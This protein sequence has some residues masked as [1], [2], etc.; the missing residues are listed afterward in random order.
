MK[1][2]RLQKREMK[3]AL[4]YIIPSFVGFSFITLI[5]LIVSFLLVFTNW[6]GS[7]LDQIKITGFKNASYILTKDWLFWKSMLH[8]VIF[9][10]GVVPTEIAL[11][12]ILAVFLN[13]IAFCKQTLRAVYFIPYI[14]LITAIT[15]V[16]MMFFQP[17]WGPINSFLRSIGIQNPPGWL[18]STKTSLLSVMIVSVWRSLGY[19]MVIF[20]AGLQTIPTELYEAAEIDG[21][22]RVKQF[23]RVT[24]PMLTPIILFASVTG[25]I[26]SFR[27]FTY[28]N[29]MT[30][31]R[32]GTSS[33]VMVYYLYQVAFKDFRFGYASTLAWM[34][35]IVIF[36]VTI[37]QWHL[38]KRWVYEL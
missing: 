26:F 34:L 9:T 37:I 32:P 15:V 1:L 5:P 36:F 29:V 2:S 25:V 21:A 24:L 27:V 30:R 12:I 8:N 20:L 3:T 14:T 10:L 19:Y 35:F 13:D 31:G 28:I 23:F 4:R 38:Q 16:W 22:G 11:A 6:D 7:F 17:S 33:Y 18:T